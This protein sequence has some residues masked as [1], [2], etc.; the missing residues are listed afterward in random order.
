M[1]AGDFVKKGAA[2]KKP[3]H[4]NTLPAVQGLEKA[5]PLREVKE[6]GTE[7]ATAEVHDKES[8]TAFLENAREPLDLVGLHFG[9]GESAEGAQAFPLHG[10]MSAALNEEAI[11]GGTAEFDV[12]FL[13]DGY[14]VVDETEKGCA[15]RYLCFKLV[16]RH[17]LYYPV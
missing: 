9:K 4:G 11:V 5:V 3:V 2:L 14:L 8:I 13:G 12:P 16:P 7:R 6:P 1:D 15:S 17:I 10:Y